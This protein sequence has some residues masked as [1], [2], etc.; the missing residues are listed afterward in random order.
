MDKFVP[1]FKPFTTIFYFKLFELGNV[2]FGPVKVWKDLEFIW[3]RLNSNFE[4]NHHRR[5]ALCPRAHM[6]VT[7]FALLLPCFDWA[8]AR[9]ARPGAATPGSCHRPG[10][11][12]PSCASLPDPPSS[13]S[14]PCGAPS[15]APSPCSLSAR[16]K[17]AT[18]RFPHSAFFARTRATQNWAL[19]P[20]KCPGWRLVHAEALELTRRGQRHWR[21]PF[22]SERCH[23]CPSR[24]LGASSLTTPL[25]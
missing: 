13:P 19:P 1:L 14:P 18:E 17:G 5:L 4:S 22:L 9:A 10:P 21:L 25:S 12:L 3:I 11:P 6:L 2:L 20:P 7:R 23:L 24:R 15:W 16:S 8:R